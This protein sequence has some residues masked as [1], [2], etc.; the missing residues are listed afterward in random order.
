MSNITPSISIAALYRF[1]ELDDHK[2]LQ[3]P[4]HKQMQ[5]LGIHGTLL[6]ARE[7]I[8]GTVAGTPDSIDMLITWLKSA[9]LWQGR[10]KRQS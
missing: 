6:L 9:P 4:L 1:V 3:A 7:G 2:A 8:N 5:Q 10:H